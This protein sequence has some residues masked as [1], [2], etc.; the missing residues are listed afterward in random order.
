MYVW[1]FLSPIWTLIII[2][3]FSSEHNQSYRN[4]SN[5]FWKWCDVFTLTQKQKKQIFR[6]CSSI[7]IGI[8]KLRGR[9]ILDI[10]FPPFILPEITFCTKH[11]MLDFSVQIYSGEFAWRCPVKVFLEILQTLQ[12]NTCFRASAS[13]FIKKETVAQVISYEIWE[14]SKDTFSYRALL[15]AVSTSSPKFKSLIWHC[16]LQNVCNENIVEDFLSQN[17]TCRKDYSD[18]CE[19]HC[20]I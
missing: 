5:I 20:H 3:T 17:A 1:S 13:N 18:R 10:Y 2:W 15:V 7:L 14:I 8:M 11:N 12:E 19:D 6:Q 4:Q 16:A 9:V